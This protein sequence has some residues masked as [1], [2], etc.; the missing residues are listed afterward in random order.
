MAAFDNLN[1]EIVRKGSQEILKT[2]EDK[3]NFFE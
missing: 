3:G 1:K 2:S